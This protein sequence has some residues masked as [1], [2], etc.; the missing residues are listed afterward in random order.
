MRLGLESIRLI[1][2]KIKSRGI[3]FIVYRRKT[4]I[5]EAVI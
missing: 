5:K 1:N 3:I 2:L 4:I